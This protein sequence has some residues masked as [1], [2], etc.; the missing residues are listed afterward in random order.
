MSPD[1]SVMNKVSSAFQSKRSFEDGNEDPCTY[2]PANETVHGV[3]LARV[4]WSSQRA[5]GQRHVT[6]VQFFL[7]TKISSGQQ[8]GGGIRVL[9]APAE[10]QRMQ[11]AG[12]S[13]S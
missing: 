11:I 12:S 4:G 6:N 2:W 3:V 5:G 10:Q 1:F 9:H 8:M 13:D 7:L